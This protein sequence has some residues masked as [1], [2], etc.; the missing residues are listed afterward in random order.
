MRIIIPGFIGGRMV[1]WLSEITVT[2]Q[3]SQNFY[4]F[5]DNRVLPSHV[6]EALAKEEGEA[7]CI[8]PRVLSRGAFG[9]R[10]SASPTW[11]RRCSGHK[12][13]RVCRSQGCKCAHA[14][15]HRTHLPGPHLV[16]ETY[17]PL[18]S[19]HVTSGW[20]YKPDFIIN[21]LNI[22][23]AV[24]R[25]WHDEVISLQENTPYTCK[26]YAYAG[27]TLGFVRCAP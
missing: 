21:D 14:Q 23:S 25:P 26:G 7:V 13:G 19:A 15:A 11:T 20:W 24:A 10:T 4:H 18:A 8:R 1:K 3:E 12:G 17:T 5:M 16:S 6:D 2:E 27:A 9:S 22:N